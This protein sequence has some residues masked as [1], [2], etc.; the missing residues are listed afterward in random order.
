MSCARSWGE[1]STANFDGPTAD[2]R[3][4]M[5]RMATGE[6]NW[7]TEGYADQETARGMGWERP[8]SLSRKLRPLVVRPKHFRDLFRGY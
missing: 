2:I 6:V 5:P 7:I 3:S 1:R 4:S 8:R